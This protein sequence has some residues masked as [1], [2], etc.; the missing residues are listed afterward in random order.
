[1]LTQ[2]GRVD[3]IVALTHLALEQDQQLAAFVP[4]L[5]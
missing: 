1:V 5:I 3:I 4:K 2:K